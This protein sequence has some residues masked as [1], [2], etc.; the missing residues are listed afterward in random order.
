MNIIKIA[1]IRTQFWFNLKLG[2]SV[3]HTL[4]VLKGFVNKNCDIKILSNEAFLGINDFNYEV[5]K[6]FFKNLHWL[7]E[8]LYNF[9]AGIDFTRKIQR[10]KPDFIYH[11]FTG[12]TFFVAKIA[13]VFNIPLILEFNSFDSW[14]I[15]NW[16]ASRN[17]MKRIIQKKILLKIVQKIE[18]YNLKK[19]SLI[20]TVSEPLKKDLI[21]IGISHKK[22][23]VNYNGVD[24]IKFD[25]LISESEKCKQIKKELS[26][27]S[28]KVVIGF[29]GTFGLWHG[30]PQLTEAIDI[31][32]KNKLS[33]N[34]QFLIIGSGGELKTVMEQKLS[35]Y[36]NIIFKGLVSYDQIQ[37]FLGVCDIL[38][39]P[40]CM[41]LENKEFFGSP[42]KV[43]EYM[44][45]GK[46]IVASNI[47]QIGRILEDNKTAI[48]VEPGNVR[49][50]V[51]AI[52]RLV[53]DKDLRLKL[54][55]NARIIVLKRYTWD[56]NIKRL[57]NRLKK[58][59]KEIYEN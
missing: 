35:N 54:G 43:F 57:I 18:Y 36:K 24:T 47:G 17:L 8:L 52:L 2:G 12:Y 3:G 44:A 11:R 49:Q 10:Y 1:Y 9:Y 33:H 51:K 25:P 4:G 27:D 48:L 28:C 14:K 40:H 41:M 23:M 37:Y 39:S 22:V 21:N 59:F 32:L 53:N 15:L 31:I 42:T 38:V 29:S 34:V 19:A 56:R 16:E 50:L 46:G 13:K 6:P 26:I 45:M 55:R 30:I 7:G 5:I 58:D 20:I